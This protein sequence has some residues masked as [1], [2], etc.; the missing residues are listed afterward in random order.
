MIFII[1]VLLLFYFL[2]FLSLCRIINKV[3]NTLAYV[4]DREDEQVKAYQ[5]L[6]INLGLF[7]IAIWGIHK[8]GHK[9]AV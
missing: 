1:F 4:L 7:A 6:T 3:K 8:Y 9:L 2:F 5:D